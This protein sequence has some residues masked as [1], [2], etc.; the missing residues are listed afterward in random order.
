MTY[1]VPFENLLY[2]KP[3]IK[4]VTKF[5]K[6]TGMKI[7]LN[8]EYSFKTHVHDITT[9]GFFPTG[10]PHCKKSENM[11]PEIEKNCRIILTGFKGL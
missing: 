8:Q 4:L 6:T 11:G 10:S 2:H 9:F 1:V 3:Q 5:D 7:Q